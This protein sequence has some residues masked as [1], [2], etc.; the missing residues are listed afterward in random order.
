MSRKISKRQLQGHGEDPL[1]KKFHKII[2]GIGYGHHSH[3]E[4]F[5]GFCVLATLALRQ[6]VV[7]DSAVE[8]EYLAAV[9]RYGNVIAR[10][11]AEL[12]GLV[13]LAQDAQ[14]QDFLGRVFMNLGFGN[15]YQGQFFT[16][17]NLSLLCARMQLMGV[18]PHTDG[19]PITINDPTCGSGGMLL[20]C[21]V[22]LL[23]EG[24]D[25]AKHACLYGTDIAPIC[26]QMAY[27]Q[28]TAARLPAVIRCADSLS[29][30]PGVAWVTPA[31]FNQF[32]VAGLD[33]LAAG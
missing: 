20:A 17:F 6:R 23:E 32:A 28:L 22:T 30:K 16:P 2:T 24:I 13:Y 27:I 19:R 33:T 12:L 8:T 26:A 14:P 3:R 15:D 25:P 11:S 31:A 10:T 29:D 9:K 4:A 1:A 21:A 5:E 18:K 7:F